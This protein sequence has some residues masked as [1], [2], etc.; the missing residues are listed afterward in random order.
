[1]VSVPPIPPPAGVEPPPLFDAQGNPIPPTGYAPPPQFSYPPMQPYGQP[2]PYG[3]PNPYG[4]PSPYGAPP[5]GPTPY[6]LPPLPPRPITS[7]MWVGQ[8]VFSIVNMVFAAV[9]LI[10]S[11]F[12]LLT[13]FVPIPALVCGIVGCVKAA[14]SSKA[15]TLQAGKAKITASRNLNIVSIVLNVFSVFLY[16]GLFIG[17]IACMAIA[18]DDYYYYDIISSLAL[19]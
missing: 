8:L 3:Q 4:A 10:I 5:Y 2:P 18:M 6:A 14:T 15:T 16:I 1:M 7:S 12:G 13:L 17:M 11:Y 19:R 9:M